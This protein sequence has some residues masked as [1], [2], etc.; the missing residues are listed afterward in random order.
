MGFIVILFVNERTKGDSRQTLCQTL[1][2]KH[3]IPQTK[4][5]IDQTGS[6]LRE[7]SEQRLELREESAQF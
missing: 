4:G 1:V 5:S 2:T 3:T 7:E 6:I